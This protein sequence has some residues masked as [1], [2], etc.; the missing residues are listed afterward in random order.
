M[1]LLRSIS[2]FLLLG[3]VIFLGACSEKTIPSESSEVETVEN[4]ENT[5]QIDAVEQIT[6][7]G[8]FQSVEGVMDKLSCFCSHGGYIETEEGTIISVC[9][10][11]TI[12]K[13]LP[14]REEDD[15]EKLFIF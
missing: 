15:I 7:T 12:E 14:I 8:S 1:M 3:T 2:I 5:Q 6:V 10:N 4:E 13:C 9:F 11:E